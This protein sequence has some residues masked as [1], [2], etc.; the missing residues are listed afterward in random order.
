[1]QHGSEIA[2]T[3][4]GGFKMKK[5][6]VALLLTSGFLVAQEQTAP[7]QTAPQAHLTETQRIAL[8]TQSPPVKT[9]S[10]KHSDKPTKYQVTENKT[11]I[12]ATRPY[13]Q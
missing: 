11:T 4:A 7:E 10:R 3:E 5:L 8:R 2:V 9:H 1:L 6:A 12:V 13:G